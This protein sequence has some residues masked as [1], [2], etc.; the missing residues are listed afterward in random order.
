M[1]VYISLKLVYEV[2]KGIVMISLKVPKTLVSSLLYRRKIAR[3]WIAI[4]IYSS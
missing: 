4:G 2:L 1:K 3:S